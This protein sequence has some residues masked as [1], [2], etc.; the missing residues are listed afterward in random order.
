MLDKI[1]GTFDQQ[2]DDKKD[3]LRSNPQMQGTVGKDLIGVMALQKLQKEKQAAENELMLA[4][5]TSP[6]TIREELENELTGMTQNEMTN[7]AQG[8][9]QQR[10]MTQSQQRKPQ[11]VQQLAQRPMGG[12]MAPR[13]PMGGGI[14]KAMGGAQ[15][16]PMMAASGGIVGYNKGGVVSDEKLKELGMS[17]AQYDALPEATKKMLTRPL[18]NQEAAQ[19]RMAERQAKLQ[20]NIV[21]RRADKDAERAKFNQGIADNKKN[22][23]MAVAKAAGLN[24]VDPITTSPAER[25]NTPLFGKQEAGLD[26]SLDPS[27]A[28]IAGAAAQ[29]GGDTAQVS[30]APSAMP[31]RRE[32]FAETKELL[33]KIPST[34][35][36]SKANATTDAISS[37]LGSE[38][39]D[40]AKTG[41]ATDLAKLE[42]DLATEK[43]TR[44]GVGKAAEGLAAVQDE[45]MKE[46]E[47][48]LDPDFLRR[49]RVRDGIAAVSKY[50]RARKQSVDEANQA[51]LDAKDQAVTDFTNQR[52]M[53]LEAIKQSDAALAASMKNHI[54]IQ[55]NFMNTLVNVTTADREAMNAEIDQYLEV[56]K[57]FIDQGLKRI[58]ILSEAELR[59]QIAE[60]EDVRFMQ[61]QLDKI[62]EFRLEA[63]NKE[64][65]RI[66][67]QIMTLQA[68]A[69]GGDTTAKGKLA[70]IQE[71]AR[72][73]ANAIGL[74][75]SSMYMA[76]I[77]E[78]RGL[79]PKA[80]MPD[81]GQDNAGGGD[82]SQDPA[83]TSKYFKN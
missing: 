54:D 53:Q 56:N 11:G 69:D 59:Q 19:K 31:P 45:A 29:Q 58:G 57:A 77:A 44:Y 40:A 48:Q 15:R 60:M 65:D 34:I 55:N 38:F 83:G 66:R 25:T 32:A 64:L 68:K 27:A 8:I 10:A 71:K 74:T 21:A 41:A 18:S 24:V 26:F 17:R 9:M 47:R 43:D 14:P 37:K 72:R 30:G 81:Y 80:F 36:L 67:P 52:N 22:Q 42:E 51:R 16:P 63:I 73:N 2:V 5:Q 79:D 23:A 6:A 3:L 75:Q 82:S 33:D 46:R 76:R 13:P 12:G 78:L 61:G 28:G 39:M 4:Q 7:Q 1:M 20:E 49:K 62:E 50:G 70:D 35:D